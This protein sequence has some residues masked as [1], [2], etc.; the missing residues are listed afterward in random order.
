MRVGPAGDLE[1]LDDLEATHGR[2]VVDRPEPLT[3]AEEGFSRRQAG[4]PYN[5]ALRQLAAPAQRGDSWWTKP[6]ADFRAHAE[7]MR[8]SKSPPIPSANRVIGINA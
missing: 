5:P 7:R 6:D 1:L 2:F 4:R 8:L 3:E